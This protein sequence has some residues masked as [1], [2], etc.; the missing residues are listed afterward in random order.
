MNKISIIVPC[1]NE[2]ESVESFYG[3]TSKVTAVMT[4][5]YDVDFEFI[6]IDDGSCDGTREKLKELATSDQRVR[7]I[8]F[9][10][11]FGKEAA[12]YAGLSEAG[13]NYCVI[14]DADLQHPPALLPQMYKAIREEGFDCCG[15]LRQ[16]RTG[17]GAIRSFFSRT[18]YKICKKLMHMDMSDGHG[19]FR[20]MN[21]AVVDA[22]L[23]M[24]EY[25]RYMKG[26]FAFV[27]FDTK[28]I[29]YENC[30]R[31]CG[32]SKWNIKSLFAYAVEGILAFSTVPLKIA[33]AVGV[34]AVLS[35][36]IGVLCGLELTV[37]A[38]LFMGGLQMLFIYILGAYMSKDY[39]ENK[40]RPVYIVKERG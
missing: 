24:K 34:I 13:G 29:P 9:S 30:E 28:W 22:I 33:G 7:Y 11:N 27:G 25:H 38:V 3:E 36:I 2:E 35:A 26:L 19:D 37:T 16:G 17:D 15:G 39:M 1:Y 4:A 8:V 10:R 40:R 12:M 18:F 32:K 5:D 21:R 14:M 23:E 20:M 6:F 31:F